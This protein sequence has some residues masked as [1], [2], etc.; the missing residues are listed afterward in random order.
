MADASN[1]ENRISALVYAGIYKLRMQSSYTGRI[2]RCCRWSYRVVWLRSRTQ[3]GG[4]V[5]LPSWNFFFPFIHFGRPP[6]HRETEECVASTLLRT[7]FLATCISTGARPENYYFTIPHLGTWAKEV[8]HLF[9]KQI[10]FYVLKKI[11]QFKVKSENFHQLV[12]ESRQPWAIFQFPFFFAQEDN[13][14][15]KK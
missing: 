15:S 12:G 5:Q 11:K 10:N 9:S 8:A 13:R 1:R 7:C 4:F 2:S 6:L 3:L 14:E